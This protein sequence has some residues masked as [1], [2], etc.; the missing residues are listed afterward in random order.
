MSLKQGTAANCY[1]VKP[2]FRKDDGKNVHRFRKRDAAGS[3]NAALR[4]DRPAGGRRLFRSGARV[5][6]PGRLR[7]DPYPDELSGRQRLPGHE[8]RFGH[9][10]HEHPRLRTYR[11][12][13]G[14]DGG[15]CRRGCGPRLHDGLRQNYDPRPLLHGGERKGDEPQAEEG[16]GAAYRHAAAGSRPP[17]QGRG[18]DGEAD[19]RG[20]VVFGR[21]GARCGAVRRDHLL[22]P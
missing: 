13:R 20:D 17:G 14:V 5:A 2:L 6:R 7:Y 22:G 1:P 4:R 21:G 18:D 12:H 11:R 15:R 16:S 19:A 8:H 9:P 3:R 10:F